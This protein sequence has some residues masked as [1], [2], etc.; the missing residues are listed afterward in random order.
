MPDPTQEQLQARATAADVRTVLAQGEKDTLAALTEADR[1]RERLE[2][3]VASGDTQGADAAR[4]RLD[5][6][7]AAVDAW[8]GRRASGQADLTSAR[9]SALAGGM[10][11]ELVDKQLPLLLLPVRLETRYAFADAA[12]SEVSF[13]PSST[14]PPALLV[15]VF[16]DEAHIHGHE[17]ELTPSEEQWCNEFA[18]RIRG[19]QDLRPWMDAW[20]DLVRRA[21]PL[22]AAY[23][24]H[25]SEKRAPGL[26]P[27]PWTR[28]PRAAALPDRFVAYAWIKGGGTPVRALAPQLVREPL[29]VGPDPLAGG[30]PMGPGLDWMRDF[31]AAVSAGMALAVPLPEPASLVER[32]IVFG[33]RGSVDS[34]RSAT[35]LSGLLDAHHYVDGL[36]VLRP[37][38]ATSAVPGARTV[39]RA[40]PAAEDLFPIEC[41]YIKLDTVVSVPQFAMRDTNGALVRDALGQFLPDRESAGFA[42]ARALGIDP[43]PFA[44]AEGAGA[45][46]ASVERSLRRVLDAAFAPRLGRLLAP[47]LSDSDFAIARQ[48]FVNDVSALGPL[49]VLRLG[50]QPYGIVPVALTA[51]PWDPTSFEARLRGTLDRLRA[52]VFEP[53]TALVPRV[54]AATAASDPGRTLI[55]ILRTDGVARQLRL[56]SL[57]GPDVAN[58]IRGAL[59]ADE[60]TAI[61]N[62]R[63][64]ARDLLTTLGADPALVRLLNAVL[65][66]SPAPVVAPM[67]APEDVAL[68]ARDTPERYLE[69]LALTSVRWLAHS[70]YLEGR[71]TPVL[72]AICRLAVL[73]T[74]DEAARQIL[75]E[76]GQLPADWDAE[77]FDPFGAPLATVAGRLDAQHP[78]PPVITFQTI[79]DHLDGVPTEPRA[80]ALRAVRTELRALRRA[81]ASGL[82]VPLRAAVGLL[83]HRLD[84]WYSALAMWKLELLRGSARP[85]DP[86][87]YRNGIGLGAWATVGRIPR[88]S[89]TPIP[90]L[91]RPPEEA[92]PLY[93]A[94]GNAGY[95]HAPSVTHAATAAVLRSAHLAHGSGDTFS[96]DLSSRRVRAALELLEGVREGQ[97]LAAL[98][99]YRIERGLADAKL[100]RL[101]APLRGLAPVI[102][103]KLTPP[104]T[105]AEAIAATNVVDGMQL[106]SLAGR[107]PPTPPSAATLAGRLPPPLAMTTAERSLLQE[108]LDDAADRLDAVGDLTLAE[109]VFQTVQGNP[110]RVGAAEASVS[111][112]PVPPVEPEIA[113]RPRPGV[114][115]THRVLFLA[116]PSPASG[117]AWDI[118]PRA[119]AEPR[120]E[121]LAAAVLPT[122]S[123]VRLHAREI[124]PNGVVTERTP[125]LADLLT[126]ARTAARPEL[127]LA[128]LDLVLGADPQSAGARSGLDARVA[129]LLAA[130]TPVAAGA[131]LAAVLERDPGWP[132]DL[133]S[134]G[135]MLEIARALRDVIIAA[136]PIRPAD[137]VAPGHA[138]SRAIDE[139]ELT[140]RASDARTA[141][142]SV[143]GKLTSATTSAALR[144]AL[145]AADQLGLA[146]APSSDRDTSD[147]TAALIQLRALERE[148]DAALS[149]L[150]ARIAAES[151]NSLTARQRLQAALGRGF[152]AVALV[153]SDSTEDQTLS[154]SAA[155]A[156]ARGATASAVRAWLTRA[157]LHRPGVAGLQAVVAYVDAH[158]AVAASPPP[159]GLDVVQLPHVPGEPWV[160]GMG[161]PPAGRA[162]LV[163]HAPAGTPDWKGDHAGL[164]IDEWVETVPLE[165]E[166]TSL[167]FHYDGPTNA[168]PQAAL[169][170]V[171]PNTDTGWQ[172]LLVLA[173]IQEALALAELRGVDLDILGGGQLLPA[174]L[175]AE[176][177]EVTGLGI[178][179]TEAPAP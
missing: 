178:E 130:H 131:Q 45:R 90:P 25:A 23:L 103:G 35:E 170:C 4:G 146:S 37:G 138:P 162:S 72:F 157:A 18:K 6:A 122:P 8:P 65:L 3:A 147:I 86:L 28:A 98:I 145:L 129:A 163:A 105:P 42:L 116:P 154:L 123:A 33:V 75:D 155:E 82:D 46:D 99:G 61:D 10:G 48:V 136:R 96:I 159:R 135:E 14:L 5:A 164:V 40:R 51:A 44:H 26:R 150:E 177:P 49:P 104:S 70:Q 127:G 89:L 110:S 141:L 114:A 20:V 7:K 113:R 118:T 179:L 108:I 143:R 152:P 134:L 38:A 53:A 144:T 102:A 173:H 158:D 140:R 34:N 24:A 151:D 88:D 73:E 21:G 128:A 94:R 119:A 74:A 2:A 107:A 176:R 121:A 57:L 101:I 168:P 64:A 115:M 41:A 58:A 47:A 142:A 81:A 56:R 97:S 69:L 137:L 85:E 71:P 171:E 124:A 12:G 54:S 93:A 27:A 153:R 60:A 172:E 174:M 132:A 55:E 125:T 149:E 169:L 95:V 166:T 133:W 120:L 92:G 1:A 77:V 50:T 106:L 100:Q 30:G 52:N 9:V 148:R 160:G 22:R 111:G 165:N 126:A 19:A 161:V 78:N 68:G 109:A 80:G 11:F 91:D 84:A 59:P 13:D 15:R 62:G 29:H 167:T 32:L 63:A 39:Y 83:S 17:P 31:R 156:A 79:G 67:V 16:P 36:G 117:G 112:A 66:E 43:L 175:A 76:F 87:G 139:N